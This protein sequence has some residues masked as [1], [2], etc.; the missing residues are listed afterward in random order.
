MWMNMGAPRIQTAI[1]AEFVAGKLRGEGEIKNLGED[2]LF[3]GTSSIPEEGQAV[4]LRLN[5]PGGDKA[6]VSGLVWWTTVSRKSARHQ[7]PGFGLR[8]LDASRTYRLA[9]ERLLR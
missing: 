2:G 9:V 3:I 5:L 7:T 4:R 6:L 8:L 1:E